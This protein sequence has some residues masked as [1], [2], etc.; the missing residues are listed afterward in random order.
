MK[1]N[2]NNI[3][4]PKT[5]IHLSNKTNLNLLKEEKINTPRNNYFRYINTYANV[6]RQ[7][8]VINRSVNDDIDKL[9]LTNKIKTA[10]N[11]SRKLEHMNIKKNN[12]FGIENEKNIN[13]INNEK[14]DSTLNN[15][16]LKHSEYN[17]LLENQKSINSENIFNIPQRNKN[18]SNKKYYY[19][20]DNNT[21]FN[22]ESK[23]NNSTFNE[24]I[25]R[26]K[27]FNENYQKFIKHTNESN[28]FNYNLKASSINRSIDNIDKKI[29]SNDLIKKYEK[30]KNEKSKLIIDNNMKKNKDNFV[31]NKLSKKNSKNK[32]EIKKNRNNNNIKNENTPF[33]SKIKE[34]STTDNGFLLNKINNRCNIN[35]IIINNNRNNSNMKYLNKTITVNYNPKD[36]R[37]NSEKND[38]KTNKIFSKNKRY[39][40]YTKIKLIHKPKIIN[41]DMK[42]N[43]LTCKKK[44]KNKI[45]FNQDNHQENK[46][47]KI[48]K[49]N[50]KAI[51]THQKNDKL[52]F[53]NTKSC[54]NNIHQKEIANNGYINIFSNNIQQK[55]KTY[56]EKTLKNVENQK[57]K[58]S[59]EDDK[60]FVDMNQKKP[61]S[62]SIQKISLCIKAEK[63]RSK[64]KNEN[65]KINCSNEKLPYTKKNNITNLTSTHLSKLN[66]SIEGSKI[67]YENNN[68]IRYS[69]IK[70]IYTNKDNK[71]NIT[72]YKNKKANEKMNEYINNESINQ[73]KVEE[74][75]VENYYTI[76][77][78]SSFIRIKKF[79]NFNIQIPI[80]KVCF[81]QKTRI[82]KSKNNK[83]RNIDNDFI[84]NG[85]ETLRENI[86]SNSY[87]HNKMISKTKN[88]KTMNRTIT[89]EK[90]ALGCSKLNKILSKNLE[91]NHLFNNGL[92][93]NIFNSQVKFNS[94]NVDIDNYQGESNNINNKGNENENGCSEK[95]NEINYSLKPIPDSHNLVKNNNLFFELKENIDKNKIIN[96]PYNN[97]KSI[98]NNKDLSKTDKTEDNYYR[99]DPIKKSENKKKLNYSNKIEIEKDIVN[100]KNDT[101][102]NIYEQMNQD[103]D[104]YLKFL[105][106][107]TKQNEE[108]TNIDE[109]Y[110]YNWK[111]IDELMVNGKT[112]LE[113]IIKT[114]IEICKNRNITKFDLPK[115][116]KYIKTIIEYYITDFSRNQI[117]IVHLNMIEL[118]KS[119]IE[120]KQNYSEIFLEILGNLLFILL[121]NKL[122]FMKDLNSFIEKDKETQINIAKIVKY[123]ILSS[124]KLLKQYHNDF[125]YTKIFNNNEI[126][127]Y[128]VTNEIPQLNKKI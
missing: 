113:D 19:A 70:K 77:K 11:T 109:N 95:N 62:N 101:I 42:T 117:E 12:S 52:F 26:F 112:K 110:S 97:L 30:N 79:Y 44:Y 80:K 58:D 121:R 126:F 66:E 76:Q 36:C 31:M 108:E 99:I 103:L 125:K 16:V 122:Y 35:N 39:I 107:N 100:N 68:N 28:T 1:Y 46:K 106:K 82:N 119:L 33:N 24:I 3:Y 37:I 123:S 32:K 14:N 105:E 17:E 127:V 53:Y 6:K 67:S 59:F 89:E 69:Y 118:F 74:N 60:S 87:T 90:F 23:E 48:F 9:N 104:N 111:T 98:I 20:K 81:N 73:S 75:K 5:N 64:P 61:Q 84:K 7:I 25:S 83:G 47:E 22:P 15:I 43:L 92:E 78:D 124:G 57:T 93:I 34:I 51:D 71:N 72:I 10:Q 18:V 86:I 29:K 128:Y 41:M 2:G 56:A 120:F 116:I 54:R 21:L 50:L 4:I 40:E 63:S 94:T 114:Y 102:I 38:F 115:F 55:Q 91:A 88:L 27:K 65:L 8:N 49:K 13:E 85:K 96:K 45:I